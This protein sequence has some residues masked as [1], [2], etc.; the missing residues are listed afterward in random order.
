MFQIFPD[1]IYSGI[2]S[3]VQIQ[4]GI[5]IFFLIIPISGSLIM[6]QPAAVKLLCP[7]Q[8]FLKITSI[9]TFISHR[10]NNHTRTVF[11]PLDTPLYPIQNRFFPNRVIRN[12]LI[13]MPEL[14][15]IAV[16]FIIN[17]N[18]TVT[19]HIRLIHHHKA[20]FIAQLIKNRSIRIMAGS[21]C[22]KIMPFHQH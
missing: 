13:P 22:I 14:I 3:A 20:I 2:H 18:R 10:P 21:Y 16:I 9:R 1:F 12:G 5:V 4:I 7:L 6:G 11:I 15:L 19:F 17:L 8:R